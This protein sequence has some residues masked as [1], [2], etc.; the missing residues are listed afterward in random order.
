MANAGEWIIKGANRALTQNLHLYLNDVA[1]TDAG[2]DLAAQLQEPITTA[3]QAL[4]YYRLTW[5]AARHESDVI[6]EVEP[7]EQVVYR[8][9]DLALHGTGKDESALQKFWHEVPIKP[10]VILHHGDYE[11][12]KRNAIDNA[13]GAGYLDAHFSTQAVRVDIAANSADVTLHLETGPAFT[14]NRVV[15]K[16]SRLDTDLL[17]K[18]STIKT[19]ERF[20]NSSLAEMY[21]GLYDSGYF[22]EISIEQK[23]AG[24]GQRD[25]VV[26][27]KDAARHQVVTGAG[28]STD[29]GARVRLGWNRP[30]INKAG[31]QLQ[32]ELRLAEVEQSFTSEYRIPIGNPLENY[33]GVN[34]G[35]RNRDVEDTSTEV[36][37]TGIALH[38]KKASGWHSRYGIEF[39]YE[40]YRQGSEPANEV[41]YT[42][43]GVGWDYVYQEGPLRL[44]DYGYKFWISTDASVPALGADSP[45]ARLMLGAKW[46]KVLH[47]HHEIQLRGE[48]GAIS[49]PDIEQVPASR[50][51]FTGGDQT[52]R[53]FSYLALAPKDD[54][55]E[56]I[57]GRYLNVASIEYR[58]RLRENWH[59]AAFVDTGRAYSDAAEPFHTGAGFGLHWQTIVGPI[60]FDIA[61]PI[62]DNEHKAVHLH[63]TMGPSL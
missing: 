34:A 7:G 20:K 63:I 37:N 55:G 23:P 28:F 13:R 46:L 51:F 2:Q 17:Q 59:V 10:G 53:G 3:A 31:H 9:V 61:K 12:F 6:I 50:R 38:N 1:V 27:L 33:V 41:F 19:G 45:F 49:Q 44:P 48:A 56:A 35:W 4:G 62:D 25:I 58:Y 5:S 30:V 14:V 29:T 60:R 47:D 18:M 26:T 36:F 39:D 43:P 54:V 52:V 15:L 22:E 40:K 32:N 11:L 42:V 8:T 16:G 57:G 21:G 24:P